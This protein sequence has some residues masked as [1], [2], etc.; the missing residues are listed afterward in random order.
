MSARERKPSSRY[1]DFVESDAAGF[2]D[3]NVAKAQ[4]SKAKKS[5]DLSKQ[6]IAVGAAK[7]SAEKKNCKIEAGKIEAGKIETGKIETGKIE[8]STASKPPTKHNRALEALEERIIRDA[9]RSEKSN[10]VLKKL[11]PTEPM[12][13]AGMQMA[14]SASVEQ[15]STVILDWSTPEAKQVGSKCKVYWDGEGLW[16]YARV[17]NYDSYHDRHFVRIALLYLVFVH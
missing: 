14:L 1:A 17:L 15:C 8:S 16:F 6:S 12:D 7:K 4:H 9:A 2:H 13:I 3:R 11:L 10:V 5:N